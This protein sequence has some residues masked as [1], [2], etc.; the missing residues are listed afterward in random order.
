MLLVAIGAWSARARND[1]K[2][3]TGSFS[4][5]NDPF[6]VLVG[7]M[8]YC[9]ESFENLEDNYSSFSKQQK[10]DSV[11]KLTVAIASNMQ[12][13]SEF[14]KWLASS[15]PLSI[16]QEVAVVA[17]S[18]RLQQANLLEMQ[19]AFMADQGSNITLQSLNDIIDTYKKVLPD[20]ALVQQY[21]S[22]LRK[23]QDQ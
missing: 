21:K 4:Y 15:P 22:E 8:R 12:H 3:F 6:V 5:T 1:L 18:K 2:K 11:R 9:I 16:E 20:Q 17:L 7:S 14:F 13:L 19:T 23:Q 10:Q